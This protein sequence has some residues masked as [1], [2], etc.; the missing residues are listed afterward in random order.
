MAVRRCLGSDFR[1]NLTPI[2]EVEISGP[3]V[4]ISGT[5]LEGPMAVPDCM[6]AVHEKVEFPEFLGA[7]IGRA[8]RMS[9]GAG[10]SERRCERMV[11]ASSGAL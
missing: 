10:P 6:R 8:P 11:G 2:V 1:T 5:R 3:R 9:G 7:R 4:E